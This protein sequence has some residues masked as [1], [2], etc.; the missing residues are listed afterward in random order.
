MW[1]SWY[2]QL[3]KLPQVT[4]PRCVHSFSNVEVTSSLH[5][6][7]DAS[8]KAY[9]A[10]AYV[11]S[12]TCAGEIQLT[13][14]MSKSRVPPIQLVSISRLELQ[15]AV[16][17]DMVAQINS[18]LDQEFGMDD[19]RYWTDSSNVLCWLNETRDLKT[20][21][22]NRVAQNH[23]ETRLGPWKHVLSALNPANAIT[24]GLAVKQLQE[25]SLWW[26]GPQFITLNPDQWP[27]SFAVPTPDTFREFKQKRAPF[28]ED[29]IPSYCLAAVAGSPAHGES[30]LTPK[31]TGTWHKL[32]RVMAYVL[33][34]LRKD[35]RKSLVLEPN[36]L[37][38]TREVQ[39]RLAQKEDGM[40]LSDKELQ[41][42]NLGVHADGLIRAHGCLA[43]VKKLTKPARHPIIIKGSSLWATLFICHV[44]G[45][46]FHHMAGVE[47]TLAEVCKAVWITKGQEMV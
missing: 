22:A 2:E 21:V 27:K 35:P 31:V 29:I 3:V 4:I 20:F 9:G 47:Q 8:A 45:K 30:I 7:C 6:F 44:H 26:H 42:L 38:C 10:C 1:E 46:V 43:H 41:T 5:V 11:V 25:Q 13:L 28:A 34:I 39:F 33:R 14:L 15:A 18:N 24:R 17:I 12:K 16:I 40:K 19:V 37:Q 32:I 23:Q 36:E